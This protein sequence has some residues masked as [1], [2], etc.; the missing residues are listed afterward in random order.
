MQLVC[1]LHGQYVLGPEGMSKLSAHIQNFE[2][3]AVDV[4]ENVHKSGMGK[5]KWHLLNHVLD[6]ISR[7]EVLYLND[8]GTY[9]G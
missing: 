4:L 5:V 7:I 8:A 2:T 6:E 9:E 1:G 3:K